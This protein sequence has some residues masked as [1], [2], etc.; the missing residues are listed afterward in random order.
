MISTASFQAQLDNFKNEIKDF[1]A[2]E[3]S[4]KKLFE[5]RLK[6]KEEK[7][8]LKKDMQDKKKGVTKSAGKGGSAPP[9]SGEY[10]V[11]AA[12]A[13]SMKDNM[14]IIG[15]KAQDLQG[16]NEQIANQQKKLTELEK[17]QKLLKNLSPEDALEQSQV[18]NAEINATNNQTGI[19]GTNLN[20]GVMS[21]KFDSSMNNTMGGIGQKI[22]EF[23]GKEGTASPV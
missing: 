14:E 11:V 23:L 9:E 20:E 8:S 19:I 18:L 6:T 3:K 10:A 17:Q 16:Q 4:E 12:M 21:L 2:E 5:T 15:G 22:I 7:R 1:K 13:V